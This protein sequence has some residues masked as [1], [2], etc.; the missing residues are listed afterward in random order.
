MTE[1]GRQPWLV[2]GVLRTSEAVGEISPGQ[3][4]ASLA[5]YSLTYAGMFVAYMVVLTHM[6]GKGA[7]AVTPPPEALAPSG[8]PLGAAAGGGGDAMDLP[9]IFMVLMGVSVLAYVVLD[10]YDLGVGMLMP[11]ATPAEQSVMV[12]SIGPFWGRERNVARARHRHPARRLPE[13]PRRGAGRALPAGRRD[14]GGSHAA[15]RRLRVPHEGAGLAPRAVELALL[16][17]SLLASFSQGFMLGRYVTGFE[18][19]IGYLFFAG[20]VG[21]SVCGGYVLLGA[22]WLVYKTEGPLQAK[23][24]TWSRWGLAW[25]A[26]V[27][28]L[29]S[30]AT[31]LVS[32]TVR[33]KWFDFPGTLASTP[34]PAACTAAG[35][36]VWLA[37][38]KIR[39]G[40]ARESTSSPSPRPS[41][42]S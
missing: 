24:L 22:T 33:A 39:R 25:V 2:A 14:A 23:A 28:A 32:E 13:G 4:G 11:A 21:A 36:W 15:R 40:T 26:L 18:D 8:A 6:A 5:A 38:G 3:L 10:G 12:S 7:Q 29:A 41:R 37:S 34:L 27:V 17:R 31:P 9:L 35:A 19:G 42:S 30:L 16:G 20:V 1:I